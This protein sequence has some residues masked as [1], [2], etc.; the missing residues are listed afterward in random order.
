MSWRESFLLRFGAGAFIGIPFGRWMRLLRDNRFAVDWPYWGRAAAITVASIPNSI[1]AAWENW[2]HARKIEKATIAPPLFILGIW[3]SGTTH[4]HNL[5]AQDDRFAYPTLYQV[6]YPHTF[7]TTEHNNGKIVA[8]LLPR[9]RAQDNVA[10]G[11]GHPQEDEFALC[12]LIGRGLAMAWAFPR[13]AEHYGRYLT[14]REA[15][16]DEIAEWKSAL[17]G[18]VRKLS[19]K[20]GKPLVLKSPGHTCRIRLLLE[21]FPDARFVHIY[22]N[23]YDVCRSTQHMIR[24]VMPWWAL[25]RPD[26]RDMEERFLRYYREAYEV[27]FAERE[28]IPKGRFHELRFEAL[29]ADPVGQLRALYEALSLPDF[30]HVEPALRCYLAA[31]AGYKKNALPELPVD[32]RKRVANEWRRCFEEWDYPV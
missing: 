13:R 27:F 7:L 18:W 14:L 20:H 15:S 22:R 29:E 26:F 16:P 24:A 11:V 10:L 5:L 4:L 25:Q 8:F 21:L 3:R 1:V 19:F 12:P 9:T 17:F 32:L 2:R 31:N 28:L 30:G 6:F 23:P